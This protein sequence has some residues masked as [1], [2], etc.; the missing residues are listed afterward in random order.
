MKKINRH[1][2]AVLAGMDEQKKTPE[3]HKKGNIRKVFAA[4]ALITA[5]AVTGVGVA[6]SA[7]SCTNP[8]GSEITNNNNQKEY[9]ENG[10][11]TK[12]PNDLINGTTGTLYDEAGYNRSGVDIDGYDMAGWNTKDSADPIN[13]FTGTAYD[14]NGYDRDGHQQSGELPDYDEN[15]WN[16]NDPNDLINGTTGGLYDE[17][18]YNR[19]GVDID[20]YD[21]AGWNT[22]DINDPINKF[23]GEIYDINGYD[24]DGHQQTGP[25]PNPEVEI[26][27]Y[28][29]GTDVDFITTWG[30]IHHIATQWLDVFDGTAKDRMGGGC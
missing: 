25:G 21:M 14:K 3:Q 24:R 29:S 20:G 23:T 26:P 13:K 8:N 2:L 10:W 19:S 28:T 16:I 4:G 30:G 18:G 1:I 6:I 15:G 12:D 5:L 11:N 7:T 17:A 22:R 9:D 27:E